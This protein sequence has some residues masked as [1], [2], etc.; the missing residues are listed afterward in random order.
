MAQEGKRVAAIGVIIAGKHRPC[1]GFSL[2][3]IAF[4]DLPFSQFHAGDAITI[5]RRSPQ[6][7]G[8]GAL[9]EHVACG[10]VLLHCDFIVLRGHCLVPFGDRL[11]RA[12]D[13]IGATSNFPLSDAL[14]RMRSGGGN[15]SIRE[16]WSGDGK[17]CEGGTER[18]EWGL[19]HI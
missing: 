1:S 14:Y 19:D 3:E 4:G 11:L 7:V 12:S 6:F 18:D 8:H 13:L 9:R 5:H 17:E 16:G 2:G 10:F 15:H